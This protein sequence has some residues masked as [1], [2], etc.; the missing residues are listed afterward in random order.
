M[1]LLDADSLIRAHEDYYPIDRVPHYWEWLIAQGSA[2]KVKVPFEIHDEIAS[3]SAGY[4]LRDWLV[5]SEVREA[6]V[7][8]EE[9]EAALFNR[10]VTQGYAPDLTDT[11]VEEMGRDPFLIA[12]AM[13]GTGRT[14]VSREV[15]AR[16][17]VRG[18]RKV[19]DACSLLNVPCM[20]DFQFLKAADFRID[21]VGVFG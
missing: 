5:R 20:T 18:R 11:E 19:P 6:L 10:V 3:V 15:S 21:R 17:K 16:S 12:Y 13:M 4:V 7:L 8:N 1:F 2:G 14:V 9:V